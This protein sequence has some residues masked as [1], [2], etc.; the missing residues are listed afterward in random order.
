MKS[1]FIDESG[2]LGK[3]GSHYFVI[4]FVMPT[5]K[6]RL[7]NIVKRFCATHAILEIK[8]SNLSFP[9]K[10]EL[11][12]KLAADIDYSLYTLT[13]N[14]RTVPAAFYKDIN[15]LFTYI[16]QFGIEHIV[17]ES[18]EDLAIHLDNRSPKTL[19]HHSLADYIKIK[20]YSE[21]GF[22][23]DIHLHYMDSSKCKG[24]QI[25]DLVANIQYARFESG[26]FQLFNLM[27][28]LKSVD[29]MINSFLRISIDKDAGNRLP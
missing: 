10:Q 23:H 8:A 15:L 1:I 9:L 21:W 5:N 17:R 27:K 24:I 29:I 12:G 4:A 28:L 20:A 6:K 11:L 22:T 19:S 18:N 13:I 25:A 3:N 26:K 7:D 16:F 2:D 14:K